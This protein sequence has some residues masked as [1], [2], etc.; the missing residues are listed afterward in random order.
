MIVK[1]H[2]FNDAELYI[3]ALGCT[4]KNMYFLIQSAFGIWISNDKRNH[5]LK[6]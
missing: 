1:I 3:Y 2:Y 4:E 6:S 5:F